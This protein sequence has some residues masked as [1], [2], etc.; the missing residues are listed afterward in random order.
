[1]NKV[2]VSLEDFLNISKQSPDKLMVIDFKASWCGPC[3]MI[4]PFM[5]ELVPNFYI[6]D[7]AM[8]DHVFQKIQR[9]LFQLPINFKPI[10]Q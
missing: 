6:L 1:M 2:E 9:Q 3:K 7:L 4:T 8:V 5:E 10:F